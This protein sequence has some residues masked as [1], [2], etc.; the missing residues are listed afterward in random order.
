[1]T[2]GQ[3]ETFTERLLSGT[4]AHEEIFDSKGHG[5]YYAGAGT[6]LGTRNPRPGDSS[7][8]RV[9]SFGRPII[10]VT[11]PQRGKLRGSRL[12][13]YFAVPHGD[14]MV[15]GCYGLLWAFAER[16]AQHR[17]EILETLGVSAKPMSG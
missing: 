11:G 2:A 16:H 1:M 5:A 3:I 7:E 6:K 12:A 17:D 8:S 4:L 13:P 10:A 9:S 14:M 15:S